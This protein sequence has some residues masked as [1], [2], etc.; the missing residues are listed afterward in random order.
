MPKC[1][2]N[3]FGTVEEYLFR[4]DFNLNKLKEIAFCITFAYTL[5]KK[6]TK[7][8]LIDF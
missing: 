5:K 3:Y 4:F 8:E 7:F 2:A 1:F 6:L